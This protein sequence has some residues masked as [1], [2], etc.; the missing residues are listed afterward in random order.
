MYIHNYA[1]KYHR[2]DV[3]IYVICG[4]LDIADMAKRFLREDEIRELMD[5]SDEE[6][7]LLGEDDQGEGW[8]DSDM[9]DS[10]Q[11]LQR[12]EDDDSDSDTILEYSDNEN[13]PPIIRNRHM[14]ARDKLIH[15]FESCFD[16]AN[17]TKYP[18]PTDDMKTE[19]K[20]KVKKDADVQ[21]EYEVT[22]S[23]IR[24]TVVSRQS[25]MNVI[26]TPG[27]TPIGEGALSANTGLS[28]WELFFDEAMQQT[29]LEYT[30]S[31]IQYVL[32]SMDEEQLQNDKSCHPKRT[33]LEELR[34]FY[35]LFYAR[36]ALNLNL[37]Y[38]RQIWNPPY[39]H[40]IFNATMS[41]H[42]FSFLKTHITFD[43][44]TTREVR[45]QHD[46]FAAMRD[47]LETAT[48]N[49][50]KT[51]QPDEYLSLDE[52]LYPM[53]TSIAFRQ[54]NKSKPAKCGMLFKS[55]NYALIPYTFSTAVY[56][57]KPVAEP[58]E[59]YI[60]GVTPIV[61]SL[62]DRLGR[63]VDLKGRN[64]TMDRLY[65]TYDLT[66]WLMTKSITTVGTLMSNR[67]EIPK[68]FVQIGE[69][70]SPSYKLLFDVNTAGKITLHSY[71]VNTKSSGLRNVLLMSSFPPLLGLTKDET[72]KPGI[73]K[74]YDFTKGGTDYVDYRMGANSTR[75]KCTRTKSPRET[76]S[77]TFTFELAM[78]LVTPHIERRKEVV[79]LQSKILRS[80]DYVIAPQNYPPTHN[81]RHENL[82]K[83][84][85]RCFM[86][87]DEYK[88]Q[89]YKAKK[90]AQCKV[91]TKCC[92]CTKAICQKHMVISCPSCD[93]ER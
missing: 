9:S 17:Y 22:W 84:R 58:T 21:Q 26:T 11:D 88:G 70:E 51:L 57:G 1:M 91:P 72:K 83:S 68:E 34:A 42:R 59:Y 86:C 19:Y 18:L 31:K 69:R 53:R 37:S 35:G 28:A 20:V 52:T 14:V 93:D 56:A 40:P 27:P 25:A 79:G 38:F 15:N 23:N 30:N 54:F 92:R 16:E 74:V 45:W 12:P 46:R 78:Q 24:P 81:I 8:V 39:G 87:K 73:Y 48:D 43:D 29:V 67:K 60:K 50:C 32:D 36:G 82:D 49:F 3:Q 71:V 6:P 44:F 10:E 62:V 65:T 75:T 2:S 89:G 76:N 13:F 66:K 41:Y 90:D 63:S 85:K 47:I 77:T 4:I 55:V 33:T 80:I 61:K 64:M 7:D 5:E